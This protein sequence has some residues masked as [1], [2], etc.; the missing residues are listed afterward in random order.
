MVDE[1]DLDR[2]C[3]VCAGL[4]F[5]QFC[6]KDGG[7]YRACLRCGHVFI[8]AL[9]PRNT[10]DERAERCSHHVSCE[11]MAW[12]FSKSKRD[13][14][15]RPRLERISRYTKPGYLLD[16]GCSNGSFLKAAESFGWHAEGLELRESSASIARSKGLTVHQDLVEQLELPAKKYQAITLWQVL[17][18]LPDPETVVRECHRILADDGVLALSTPNI[19]SIGWWLLKEQWPPVEPAVHYHLFRARNVRT[20][21]R[22]CGFKDVFL[23]CLDLQ[24]STLQLV[25]QRMARKKLEKPRNA[26]ARLTTA[27]D[28]KRLKKMFLLLKLAN[29]PLGLWGLGEDVYGYFTKSSSG[30]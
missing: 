2:A 10:K 19:G 3:C 28:Q 14:V 21:M 15:Y 7:V 29:I 4:T 25:K 24:P 26:A 22:Q 5:R 12:D 27:L 6:Q 30:R 20:L 11:K 1:H 18:H 16:I 8:P 9:E 13:L 23:R 17:E